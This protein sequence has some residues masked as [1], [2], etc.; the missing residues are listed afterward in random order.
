MLGT[1]FLSK[2]QCD[3]CQEFGPRE[4]KVTQVMENAS[5]DVKSLRGLERRKGGQCGVERKKRVS[6][7]F[8]D[9]FQGRIEEQVA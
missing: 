4:R 6:S 9:E 3:F 7:K 5:R 2:Y 1:L 8:G